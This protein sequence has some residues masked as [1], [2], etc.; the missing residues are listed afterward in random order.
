MVGR[1]VQNHRDVRAVFL[2]AFQLEATQF[3]HVVGII[4]FRHNSGE[5]FAYIPTHHHIQ[6]RFGE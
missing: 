6:A 4:A 2:N 3:Q 5:T 1:N